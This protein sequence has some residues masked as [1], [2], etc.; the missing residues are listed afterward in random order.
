MRDST[1]S[2]KLP[3]VNWSWPIDLTIYDRSPDLSKTEREYL[4]RLLTQFDMKSS[5]WPEQSRAALDRL[6]LPINDVLDYLQVRK[7]LTRRRI[8]NTLLREMHYRNKTFWGWT[9]EEWDEFLYSDKSS[10]RR[11]YYRAKGYRQ[12]LMACGYLLTEFRLLHIISEFRRA[13]F[14]ERVF[15]Q[16][17]VHSM[18]E[19]V[20]NELQH[21]G[22]GERGASQLVPNALCEAF[23]INRS[24]LLEG[25]SFEL[26]E[27]L[28]QQ[29][30]ATLKPG[31][32]YLS[33]ALVS[34][35]FLAKP[36]LAPQSVQ[37][38]RFGEQGALVGV[39]SEWL[40]WCHRWHRT[41]TLRSVTRQSVYYKLVQ[42]GRWLSASHPEITA[43]SQWTRELAAEYVAAVVKLKIGDW[44][45]RCYEPK[46]LGKPLTAQVKQNHLAALR[47]FFLDCQEWNWIPRRFDPSRA[48]TTPRS[49]R[50][51]IAP[52]PRVIADDVWAKLLWA[53]LNL[54]IDD[55]PARPS[56]RYS[57]SEPAKP[58]I[59]YPLKMVHALVLVWLFAGLRSD[60]I[61]RLRVGCVRWQKG[62]SLITGSSGNLSKD[63]VCLLD[64]P[65]NKT[66]TAFTKPVDRLVGEALT[67]WEKVRPSQPAELDPKTGE[68]VHYIFSYRS[69]RVGSVYLNQTAIPMLCRKA[70][71]PESD[72]RGDITSHRAR[73]T[74]ASQLFNS[75]EPMTLFELQAWLG[76]SSPS[77]T[78]HYAKVMP[79]KLT[80]SYVKAGY[81]ERN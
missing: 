4:E 62:E 12:H 29:I 65:A 77:S 23:L 73:S 75:K 71:I 10:G 70:G 37:T 46:K 56:P 41:S 3:I 2:K 13:R 27:R 8:S 35:G 53:G 26:L 19:C 14:T 38:R 5:F 72:A 11:H 22:F 47:L 61:Y 52:N 17:I 31:V 50:A 60:E 25:I 45:T 67:D 78:Q 59:C 49:I 18:F 43:P 33:R 51:L 79:T 58:L 44:S 39:S 21:L 9:Q 76:H 16:M 54:T 63:A 48:L 15:G 57:K 28:H 7:P 64:V 69:R 66:N 24:P 36:L 42:V 68:L 40:E 30:V 80:K 81:F 20:L 32:V 1:L 6:L 34:L 55:L 74:I